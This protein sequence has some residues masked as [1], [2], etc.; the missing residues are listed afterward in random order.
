MPAWIRPPTVS[1]CRPI[2]GSTRTWAVSGAFA[3]VGALATALAEDIGLAMTRKGVADGCGAALTRRVDGATL[4]LTLPTEGSGD[5]ELL[6]D[7]IVR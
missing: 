4:S 7:A 1:Q 5:G 3:A 2:K 6:L